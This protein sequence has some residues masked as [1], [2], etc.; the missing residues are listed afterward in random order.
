MT[1]GLEIGFAFLGLF[2]GSPIA[3]STTSRARMMGSVGFFVGFLGMPHHAIADE[4]LSPGRN[5][6][7]YQYRRFLTGGKRRGAIGYSSGSGVSG[8]GSEVSGKRKGAVA[9]NV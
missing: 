3:A 8:Q 9:T 2:R 7:L 1:F 6:K 4:R 5:F